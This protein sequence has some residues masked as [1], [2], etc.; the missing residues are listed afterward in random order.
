[1]T[2]AWVSDLSLRDDTN[3]DTIYAASQ[4]PTDLS[5]SI[6][7]RDRDMSILYKGV[8][9]GMTTSLYVGAVTNP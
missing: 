6:V 4:I 7:A 2:N 8:G 9:T 1:M 5:N 3:N